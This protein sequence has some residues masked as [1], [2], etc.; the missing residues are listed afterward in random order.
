MG[1]KKTIRTYLVSLQSAECCGGALPTLGQL[2]AAV[3]TTAVVRL[4]QVCVCVCLYV[5]SSNTSFTI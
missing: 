3:Q 5:C 4:N 2:K 1:K